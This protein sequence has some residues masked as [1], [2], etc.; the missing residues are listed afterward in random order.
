M[1]DLVTATY[2]LAIFTGLLALV[3]A[4][5]A[6]YTRKQV[7]LLKIGH[8]LA[9][10]DI[11]TKAAIAYATNAVGFLDEKILAAKMEELGLNKLGKKDK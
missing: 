10:R 2:F 7:N 8:E 11:A 5:Y 9:K 4:I 1:D 3:T 6:Y